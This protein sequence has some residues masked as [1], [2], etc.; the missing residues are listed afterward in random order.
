[1]GFL[2]LGLASAC[3]LLHDM[4]GGS[5]APP[6]LQILGVA[7]D[8]GR[9]QLNCNRSCCAPLIADGRRD[10]V[11]ALAISGETGWWLVDATP[12]IVE[13]IHAMGEMPRGIFLTHAHMG[14]YTGLMQLGF[15]SMNADHMPVYCSRSMAG[16]LRHNGPWSQLVEMGQ[17]Q[18]HEVD[19]GHTITLE[20]GL[21]VQPHTVNHRAEYTNTFAWEVSRRNGKRALWLP[22]LDRWQEDGSDLQSLANQFDYL[23]LDGT[24]YSAKELPNRDLSDIPHPLV[25]TSAAFLEGDFRAQVNFIHLNHSN[26]LWDEHSAASIELKRQGHSVPKQGNRFPL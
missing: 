26:P 1:M 8:A 21:Y 2:L 20:E 24:F 5:V 19:E 13:Q 4:P 11:A 15:E 23:F 14:H 25:K 12:D 18:L 22:D 17:I 10:P 9:P 3:Q 6:A 16:Y 7:Q